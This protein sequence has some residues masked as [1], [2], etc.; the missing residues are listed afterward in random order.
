MRNSIPNWNRRVWCFG[1]CE[2]RRSETLF[3]S[4]FFLCVRFTG[5]DGE[6]S[7]RFRNPNSIY[8]RQR[9]PYKNTWLMKVRD[10]E[11]TG[12]LGH[13]AL[14][15]K[16]W[17][18]MGFWQRW[19]KC[20]RLLLKD[21]CETPHQQ[22][23]AEARRSQLLLS[24]HPTRF[25]RR[26]NIMRSFTATVPIL[27]CRQVS[28]D[29]PGLLSSVFTHTHTIKADLKANAVIIYTRFCLYFNYGKTNEECSFSYNV[30]IKKN[31]FRSL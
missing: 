24:F 20:E 10:E 21:F 4:L 27:F 31:H 9:N 23:W 8:R 18:W 14:I 2:P 26:K 30:K 16:S 29:T 7:L 3:S 28:R 13:G 11:S 25:K 19:L 5:A 15:S 17:L 22:R 12:I 1:K 6:K